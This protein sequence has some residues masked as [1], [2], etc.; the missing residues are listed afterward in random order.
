[1]KL[2]EIAAQAPQQDLKIK[3]DGLIIIKEND[4]SIYRSTAID[5]TLKE[6]DEGM[7]SDPINPVGSKQ[8][9]LLY[10]LDKI[11][12]SYLPFSQVKDRCYEM[13]MAEKMRKYEA[14]IIRKTEAIKLSFE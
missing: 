3:D 12:V 11:P 5:S 2:G 6:L 14:E 9:I 4:H 7:I 1:M 8:I 13:V 10:L